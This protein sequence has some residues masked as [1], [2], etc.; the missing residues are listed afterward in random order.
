ML[1]EKKNG[2]IICPTTHCTELHQLQ[3]IQDYRQRFKTYKKVIFQKIFLQNYQTMIDES[4]SNT[5]KLIS[6]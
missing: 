3:N 5:A 4:I 2:Q 6:H 1:Q